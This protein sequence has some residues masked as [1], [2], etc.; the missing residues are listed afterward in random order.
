M[1]GSS[2]SL[3]VL[4]KKRGVTLSPA[5]PPDRSFFAR[6]GWARFSSKPTIHRRVSPS[7][8][9]NDGCGPG[10]TAFLHFRSAEAGRGRQAGGCLS[11]KFRGN[12]GK[13]WPQEQ[14]EATLQALWDL[15]RVDDV[16]TLLGR[17]TV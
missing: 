12:I 16:G 10:V 3:P 9:T 7:V 4:A 1:H 6:F 13:R 14:T 5:V 11:R 17:L 2:A 15:D 8:T